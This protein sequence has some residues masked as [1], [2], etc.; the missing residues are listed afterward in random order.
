M[1]T[2][3][4]HPETFE[5]SEVEFDD[6]HYKIAEVV[7]KALA[8]NIKSKGGYLKPHQ[9]T[10]IIVMDDGTLRVAVVKERKHGEVVAKKYRVLIEE[11]KES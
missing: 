8:E 11:I 9:V 10:P 4:I 7:Q 5:T 2:Q 6:F 1:K 3:F